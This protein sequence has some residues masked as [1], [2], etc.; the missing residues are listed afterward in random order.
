MKN[1]TLLFITALSLSCTSYR[2]KKVTHKN[3]ESYYFP[4]KK[5]LITNWENIHRY[6][7]NF[8]IDWARQV[9]KEDKEKPQTEINYLY[10]N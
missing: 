6:D 3:G 8:T 10:E 9:I 4:Q 7:G 1:L 5:N 2:I